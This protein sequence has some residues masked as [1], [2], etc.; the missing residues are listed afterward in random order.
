MY[1]NIQLLEKEFTGRGEVRGFLF[2]ELLCNETAYIYRVCAGK[3][4][5]EVFER[6]NTPVCVDYA[7]RIYSE[8]EFKE[9]YPKAKDFGVWAWTFDN[10]E[11]AREKYFK[12]SLK[13]RN[14][15]NQQKE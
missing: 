3:C 12:I 11:K 13:A 7:K 6:K 14:S 4:H 10:F 9:I 2:V 15:Q 5:Y 8:T 1:K